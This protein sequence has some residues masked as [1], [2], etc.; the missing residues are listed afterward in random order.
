MESES[1]NPY[2][3]SAEAERATVR[4]VPL[5][6]YW[7]FVTAL[8]VLVVG[9]LL[10]CSFWLV[11]FAV[12]PGSAIRPMG[13]A[14]GSLLFGGGTTL[15]SLTLTGVA[16]LAS[17]KRRWIFGIPLALL[18]LVPVPVAMFVCHS[19]AFARNITFKE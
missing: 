17:P 10:S 19:I 2:A 9:T 15:L 11:L 4:A 12:E 16:V 1:L 5:E 8:V 14:A 6:G 13:E 3:A 7:L 18:S